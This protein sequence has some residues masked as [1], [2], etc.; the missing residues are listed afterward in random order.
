MKI[1]NVIQ[2]SPEWSAL[3]AKY[4]TASESQAMMGASKYQTR[5]QLIE[6]K[7]TGIVPEVNAHQQALF[8]RGHQTEAATREIIEDQRGE[9]FYPITG[10]LTV[11]GLELL[12]SMDGINMEDTLAF[13]HKLWNEKLVAD[14]EEIGVPETHYW[15]LEHQALVSGVDK[16]LFVVSDGAGQRAEIVYTTDPARREQL[17][18]GWHQFAKDLATYAPEPAKV[19]VVGT[20]LMSLPSLAIALTGSVDSSNLA[21]YKGAAL[22]MIESINTDL[23]T[24]QDFADAEQVVKLCAESE[25]A[26][27]AAKEAALSQTADIDLLFKTI[28]HLRDSMRQ[29]RLSLDKLIKN[30]KEVMK[31]EIVA[32]AQE[33][34]SAYYQA[35]NEELARVNLPTASNDFA[36]AIKGKRNLAS[37][38]SAVND[39][40]ASAKIQADAT[41]TLFRKNLA[42]LNATDQKYA[43]LFNDLQ[44]IIDKPTDDFT[45]LVNDRIDQQKAIDAQAEADRVAQEAIDQQKQAE[46]ETP[47]PTQATENKPAQTEQITLVKEDAKPAA[48]KALDLINAGYAELEAFNSKYQNVKEFSSICEE[49]KFVLL[50]RKAA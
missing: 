27:N 18:A 8:D 39:L 4:F 33:V 48:T 46:P 41:A 12:A 23:Q 2:G 24:D 35:L 17:I 16:I 38:K 34:V 30:Q 3:R 40:V 44:Q 14:L 7:A 36:G 13:E 49:I 10:T 19:E 45:R 9:E 26:L 22:A 50:R 20:A 32:D 42:A 31:R 25:K 1:E 6:Q 11:E 5:D 37:I 29:K 28:D 47:A 21:E 15:Q 43:G